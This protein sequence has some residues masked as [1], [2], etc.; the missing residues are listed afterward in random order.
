MDKTLKYDIKTAIRNEDSEIDIFIDSECPR[1]IKG[2]KKNNIVNRL[3]TNGLQIEQTEEVR[4]DLRFKIADAV[5]K[6]L[7]PKIKV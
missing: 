3:S 1:D 6:V 5:V 4:D 7:G 2:D